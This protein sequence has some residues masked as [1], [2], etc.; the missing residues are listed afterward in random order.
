MH[1]I[2][3]QNVF[4]WCAILEH[5]INAEGE[6]KGL[7]RALSSRRRLFTFAKHN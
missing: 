7:K 5:Q 6:T 1:Q 4:I 3:H 2:G